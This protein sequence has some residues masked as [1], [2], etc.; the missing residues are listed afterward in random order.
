MRMGEAI[1]RDCDPVILALGFR[2]PKKNHWDRWSATR[3]NVYIRWRGTSYDEI[4]LR[5]D[6]YNRPK[7]FLHYKTSVV[8]HPPREG[9]EA[10]RLV[11]GG[12]MAC[13]RLSRARIGS[14]WFGPWRSPDSVAALVNRR[15][16]DLDA[17]FL[18]GVKHP[19][20]DPGNPHRE[21]FDWDKWFERRTW[22]DP[23]LDAESDYKTG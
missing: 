19:Y 21:P 1:R 7:F 10:Q 15:V 22:G 11:M 4:V 20:L 9:Q 16:H 14:D 6:K 3:R 5:W 13:W 12:R 8:E 18:S 2:N 23:W 17:F